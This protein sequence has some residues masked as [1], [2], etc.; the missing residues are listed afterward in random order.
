MKGVR[1]RG[2]A[3][4]DRD[5]IARLV[6]AGVREARKVVGQVPPAVSLDDLDARGSLMLVAAADG[7]VIG[8]VAYRIRSATLHMFNLIVT[9]KYR[10]NGVARQ[11]V[12]ELE[13][14]AVEAGA[15]QVTV[16][17]VIELGVEPFFKALGYRAKSAKREFLFAPTR[18]RALTTVYMVKRLGMF[19]GNPT[20]R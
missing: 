4:E 6:D 11:L 3:R 12:G 2:A 16:Q 15:R 1:I 13:R 14:I 9:P 5:A 7:R 20:K 10:R 17:T 19:P 18:D 8:S